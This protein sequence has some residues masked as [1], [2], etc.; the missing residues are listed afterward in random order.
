VRLFKVADCLP[1][2]FQIGDQLIE[3]LRSTVLRPHTWRLPIGCAGYAW[4]RYRSTPWPCPGH[5]A[6]TTERATSS[7]TSRWEFVE[8]VGS[9]VTE[10]RPGQRVVIPFNIACGTC[11]MC[12]QGLQSQCETTQ[13]RDQ[14]ME[15]SRPAAASWYSAWDRSV[16]YVRIAR[17]RGAEKVIGVDL[18]PERLARTRLHGAEA[19]DL[20]AHQ[21]DLADVIRGMTDGRGPDAVIDAVGM[22]A[23]G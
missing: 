18:V 2:Q 12:R 15:G 17:H 4:P 22:E 21:N 9:E 6:E 10:I 23:P 7:A 3:H 5:E 11:F 16:T 20:G 1:G 14:G 8:E 13:V 19:L